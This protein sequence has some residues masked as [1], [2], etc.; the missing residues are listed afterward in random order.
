[1][2]IFSDFGLTMKAE[3]DIKALIDMRKASL[4]SARTFLDEVKRRGLLSDA[5][6]VDAEIALTVDEVEDLPEPSPFESEQ[7]DIEEEE[8]EP[9][10]RE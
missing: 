7:V 5:I 3:Q 4:I 10:E 2:D 1:M 8:E 9:D 6:D